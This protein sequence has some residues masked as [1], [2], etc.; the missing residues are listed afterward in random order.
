LHKRADVLVAEGWSRTSATRVC[1]SWR[2]GRV[3]AT[4]EDLEAVP[5]VWLFRRLS[6]RW[7]P[8][9]ANGAATGSGPMR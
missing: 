2:G 9:P 4:P 7:C 5:R 6:V 3:L 8:A 1:A